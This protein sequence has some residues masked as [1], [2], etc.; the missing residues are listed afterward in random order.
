MNLETKLKG[1][2]IEKII[3]SNITDIYTRLKVLLGL[4]LSGHTA[5]LTETSN[6][7]DDLYKRGETVNKQ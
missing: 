3:P 7:I 1:E 2:G 4:E 6:L 5:I